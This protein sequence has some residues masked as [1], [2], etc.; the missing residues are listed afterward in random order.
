MSERYQALLIETDEFFVRRVGITKENFETVLA[1]VDKYISDEKRRNPITRRGANYK[2]CLEDRLLLTLS[3]LRDYP[4]FLVLGKMF[5]ISESQ[6]NK[7][8]HSILDILVKVVHVSNRKEL[9]NED[10]VAIV[11]DVTEQPIERPIVHQKEYYSGKK[12][13]I[14]LKFN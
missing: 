4:T 5:D 10:L 2:V 6:A 8:Y 7:N 13:D 12:K 9:L 11:I 1:R 3:Y 14:L